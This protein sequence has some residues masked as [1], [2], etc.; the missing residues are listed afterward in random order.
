RD[1]LSLLDQVL[2]FGSGPV[3][4]ARVREVLGL[5]PDERYGELLRVIA[6]HDAKGAFALVE[7]LL[8]AGGSLEEFVTGAGEALR[9]V[10][11]LGVGGEPE[12]LTEGMA[13]T[14]KTYAT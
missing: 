11:L 6:E 3:T 2:S 14:L 13:A 8:G 10:L 1:A 9:A 12:G 5:I 4:P 7:R